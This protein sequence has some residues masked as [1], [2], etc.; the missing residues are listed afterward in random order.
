MFE[1]IRVP[2]F[3]VLCLAVGQLVGSG[4]HATTAYPVPVVCPVCAEKLQAHVIGSTNNMGGQD[5]DFF[6]R[7]AGSPAFM[8]AITSCPKCLYSGFEKDFVPADAEK[9]AGP[10]I[11]AET[12]QAILGGK[13]LHAPASLASSGR[14]PKDLP[15]WAKLDLAAQVAALQGVDPDRLS[16]MHQ[17]ASWSVRIEENPFVGL[18]GRVPEG[19]SLDDAIDNPALAEV[20]LG[21]R[22]LEALSGLE[23]KARREAAIAAGEL[24]RSHGEHEA[25]LAGLPAIRKAIGPE[26]APDLE[27]RVRASIELERSYLRKASAVLEQLLASKGELPEHPVY[28]YL[29]GELARRLGDGKKAELMLGRTLVLEGAPEWVLKYAK[30]Q[31]AL[32]QAKPSKAGGK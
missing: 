28:T 1:R 19:F 12:R 16:T 2:S 8:L 32:V 15:A 3:V 17:R 4:A 5:R 11:D 6:S 20:A 22:L 27:E 30:E 14:D 25:L 10:E 29:V 23:G 24:L 31:L 13:A 21:H 9:G 26:Q 18:G 7:A